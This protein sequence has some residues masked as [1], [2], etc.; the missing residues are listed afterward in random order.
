[1]TGGDP[2]TLACVACG[3]PVCVIRPPALPP[4]VVTMLAPALAA[5]GVAPAAA[6]TANDAGTLFGLPG[7]EA[8]RLL[9]VRCLTCDGFNL[10]PEAAA[11]GEKV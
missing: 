2:L 1:M 8:A 7:D 3:V 4:F 10:Q 5:I 9:Y 11:N 6:S